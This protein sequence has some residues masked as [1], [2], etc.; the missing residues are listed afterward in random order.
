MILCPF[1]VVSALIIDVFYFKIFYYFYK[2]LILL[3]IPLI[4]KSIRYALEDYS[5]YI[6]TEMLKLVIVRN[7]RRTHEN[8]FTWRDD[9]GDYPIS[10]EELD[11]I[12][13]SYRSFTTI[14]YYIDRS[15]FYDTEYLPTKIFIIIKTMLYIITWGYLLIRMF[16]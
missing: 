8:I 14:L 3:L 6:L 12:A 16:I 15:R 2:F 9:I 13:I 11:A 10:Q 1:I 5:R 4:I 7:N